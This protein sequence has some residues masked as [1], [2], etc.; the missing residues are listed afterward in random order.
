M[1]Y[2]LRQQLDLQDSRQT[3]TMERSHPTLESWNLEIPTGQVVNLRNGPACGRCK[4]EFLPFVPGHVH[5]AHILNPTPR[6][7]TSNP[8]LASPPPARPLSPETTACSLPMAA[9]ARVTIL[10][11]DAAELQSP[12]SHRCGP[13]PLSTSLVQLCTLKFERAGRDRSPGGASPCLC[14]GNPLLAMGVGDI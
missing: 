7:L 5:K 9:L 12:S 13:S 10:K 4:F 2:A 11:G 6:F 14:F 3:A 1:D 8:P